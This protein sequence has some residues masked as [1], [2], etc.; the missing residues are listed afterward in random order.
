MKYTK[1]DLVI[2]LIKDDVEFIANK[3]QNRGEEVVHDVEAQREYIMAKLIE[4]HETLQK[5]HIHVVP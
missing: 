5:L 4:V 2:T 1:E 3:V